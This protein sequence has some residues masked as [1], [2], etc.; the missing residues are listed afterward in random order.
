[1]GIDT[2]WS[3][4]DSVYEVVD[5]GFNHLCVEFMIRNY[6]YSAIA[7]M[8]GLHECRYFCGVAP[9]PKQQRILVEAYYN[10]CLKVCYLKFWMR[11]ISDFSL[12]YS[13]DVGTLTTNDSEFHACLSVC[14]FAY[15][16]TKIRQRDISGSG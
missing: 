2:H 14:L 11:Y 16:L 5:A 4:V 1:M 6:S 10:E 7:I 8:R 13:W 15:F 12:R 9:N 3:T